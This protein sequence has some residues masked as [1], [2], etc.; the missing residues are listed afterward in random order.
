[1]TACTQRTF[2]SA[3]TVAGRDHQGREVSNANGMQPYPS[4]RLEA[5]RFDPATGYYS[6]RIHGRPI[7]VAHETWLGSTGWGK[8]E[9]ATRISFVCVQ[10]QVSVLIPVALS[11][12]Q[13]L[14]DFDPKTRHL[15]GQVLHR[16]Y[17]ACTSPLSNCAGSSQI[18]NVK[19]NGALQDWSRVKLN[20]QRGELAGD[21]QS[22]NL[23][24]GQKIQLELDLG[25]VLVG[26][27]ELPVGAELP[28]PAAMP[29]AER[30]GIVRLLVYVEGSF[31]AAFRCAGCDQEARLWIDLECHNLPIS[32]GL[33]SFKG[34]RRNGANFV[35]ASG[36]L[37]EDRVVELRYRGRGALGAREQQWD[38]TMQ[39]IPRLNAEQDPPGLATYNCALM[40]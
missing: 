24:A 20:I 27:N 2:F 6:A 23:Q 5:C 17:G 29:Q 9:H 15:K 38:V 28:K 11:A 33:G 7:R 16:P 19:V 21:L 3:D 40:K 34:S 39:D 30:A 8:P 26:S 12:N 32:R 1:M 14:L 13:E 4:P 18:F 22:L 35:E 31:D 25:G 36:T 37:T 10:D